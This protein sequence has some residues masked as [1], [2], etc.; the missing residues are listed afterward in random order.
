MENHGFK[1]LP[2]GSDEIFVQDAEIESNFSD[3]TLYRWIR[4]NMIPGIMR[5]GGMV[6]KIS[7]LEKCRE[8][9]AKYGKNKWFK[10]VQWTPEERFEAPTQPPLL[11]SHIAH[12]SI[13]YDVKGF[14]KESKELRLT[15]R[16]QELV[17]IVHKLNDLQETDL[18]AYLS[19][20][21]ILELGA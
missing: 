17:G 15:S 9:Y 1:R 8:A 12:I 3:T 6:V 2:K 7:A 18:S 10:K 19:K 16:Q 20:K 4:L 13:G 14:T 11:P 5:K 21:I